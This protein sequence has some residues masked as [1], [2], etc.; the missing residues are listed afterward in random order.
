MNVQHRKIR[1]TKTVTGN[2]PTAVF[3]LP[4]AP[5]QGSMTIRGSVTASD[6][7]AGGAGHSVDFSLNV[8]VNLF[9]GT[10]TAT[11]GGATTSQPADAGLA[12]LGAAVALQ[13]VNTGRVTEL[14][15]TGLAAKTFAVTADLDVTQ[16]TA[17]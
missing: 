9:G 13:F 7:A 1:G 10:L 5:T 16:V 8:C 15:F 11:G 4:Q 14:Q 3:A 2:T 6:T 12:V 17:P